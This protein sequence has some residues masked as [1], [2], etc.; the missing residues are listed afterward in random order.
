MRGGPGGTENLFTLEPGEHIVGIQGRLS[1][2][3]DQLFFTTNFGE[4]ESTILP[5]YLGLRNTLGR[6]SSIYGG[7]AGNPFKCQPPRGR[8]NTAMRLSYIAG[9]R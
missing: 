6:T 4:D 5:C 8:N 7:N 1:A 3:I 2:R 9:K